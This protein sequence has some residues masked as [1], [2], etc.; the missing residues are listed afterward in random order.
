MPSLWTRPGAVLFLSDDQIVKVRLKNDEGNIALNA[1]KLVHLF[2][3]KVLA[4]LNTKRLL[5]HMVFI[6]I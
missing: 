2:S 3:D 1:Q 4:D 5:F 6:L